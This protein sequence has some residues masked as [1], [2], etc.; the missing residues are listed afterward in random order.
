MAANNG[1]DNEPVVV[2]NDNIAE[3]Y[4]LEESRSRPQYATIRRMGQNIPFSHRS[5]INAAYDQMEEP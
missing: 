4:T 3:F 2:S 1:G 5:H